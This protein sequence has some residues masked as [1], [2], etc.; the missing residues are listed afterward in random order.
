LLAARATE[1]GGLSLAYAMFD[2]RWRDKW[3]K[4]RGAEDPPGNRNNIV[5]VPAPISRDPH[6]SYA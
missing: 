1:F 6:A 4:D 2:P 5:C 3:A